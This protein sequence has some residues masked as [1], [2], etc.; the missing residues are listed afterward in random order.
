MMHSRGAETTMQFAIEHNDKQF[1]YE[2]LTA[3]SNAPSGVVSGTWT[4]ST[5]CA[6]GE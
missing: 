3:S 2:H 5:R 4:I 6:N 1:S